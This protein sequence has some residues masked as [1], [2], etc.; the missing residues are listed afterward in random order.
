MS[1]I[2][3]R[4]A[5]PRRWRTGW[6][7]VHDIGT[8]RLASPGTRLVARILDGGVVCTLWFIARDAVGMYVVDSRTSAAGR[9]FVGLAILLFF[10]V[11]YEVMQTAL[12]G[13]TLGKR[14]VDIRVVNL[15]TGG[16]PGWGRSLIRWAVPLVPV[17]ALARVLPPP[18]VLA[19][20]VGA[21][22]CP[23]SLVWDRK[24]QG[25]HDKAAGTV[26]VRTGNLFVEI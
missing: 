20:F 5:A 9:L 1:D 15:S 26:V 7:D 3:E 11:G 22:L 24:N 2:D 18:V 19:A 23:L 25:W 4:R 21:V 17:A 10:L 16:H 12:W 6:V 14:I 8:V 13:R